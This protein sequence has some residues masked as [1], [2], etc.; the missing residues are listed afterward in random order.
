MKTLDE[1][2]ESAMKY[3]T[4]G[5]FGKNNFNISNYKFEEFFNDLNSKNEE[6]VLA[7]GAGAIGFQDAKASADENM[8]NTLK[9]PMIVF[10][11]KKMIVRG[12]PFT[13][14]NSMLLAKNASAYE[15]Q[16][17]LKNITQIGTRGKNI[18]MKDLDGI[19][20]SFGDYNPDV[21]GKLYKDISDV[22]EN[23]KKNENND[24]KINA[25]SF[26]Q[27]KQFKDLLD[28]GIITQEEFDK[29]KK[30]LL[31]L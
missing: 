4:S 28:N 10:T 22:L 5:L 30:E 19:E 29:K 16:V 18:V 11:D 17:D 9:N 15:R 12:K 23:S 24:N 26:E 3:Q 25:N 31:G 6:A 20:I 14:A 27:I 1:Y 21:V 7:I 8:A 2:I 13:V